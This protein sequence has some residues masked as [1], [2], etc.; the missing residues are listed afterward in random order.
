MLLVPGLWST[1]WV[2]DQHRGATDIFEALGLADT[3]LSEYIQAAWGRAGAHDL[4]WRTNDVAGWETLY[5]VNQGVEQP[6]AVSSCPE[7]WSAVQRLPGLMSGTVFGNVFLST[8]RPGSSIAL[9]CGP[10]NARHRLHL[11]PCPLDPDR[12]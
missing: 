1:P 9:H 6:E 5:F 3:I 11:G 8:L 7:T 12:C 10:T 2:T 4:D